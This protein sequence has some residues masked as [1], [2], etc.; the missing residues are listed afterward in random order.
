MYTS[1]TCSHFL[2]HKILMIA[3]RSSRQRVQ[4]ARTAAA[5]PENYQERL[6]VGLSSTS[7]VATP[8]GAHGSESVECDSLCLPQ[9]LGPS[10]HHRAG[11][12]IPIPRAAP[13]LSFGQQSGDL[14][15]AGTA[16]RLQWARA[17]T[18]F[19]M[20][21]SRQDTRTRDQRN[22]DEANTTTPQS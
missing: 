10:P 13:Y 9:S 16:W 12:A 7:P 11:N 18:P 14:G 15:N 2:S 5:T 22:F 21:G 4:A 20:S 1:M 19:S 8:E 3:S 6:T 17:T